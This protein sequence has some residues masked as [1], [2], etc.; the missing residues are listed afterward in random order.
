MHTYTSTKKKVINFFFLKEEEKGR[1]TQAQVYKATNEDRFT[2]PSVRWS[3][4]S[5]PDPKNSD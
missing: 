1:R 2:T 4:G 5:V 3:F